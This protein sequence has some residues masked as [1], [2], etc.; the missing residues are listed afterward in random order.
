MISPFNV[1]NKPGPVLLDLSQRKHA[2][3]ADTVVIAQKAE[4]NH[5]KTSLMVKVIIAKNRK[6]FKKHVYP[7]N[8][9]EN[10]YQIKAKDMGC[11]FRTN[12]PCLLN[13]KKSGT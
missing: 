5:C 10:L 11:Y 13:K 3:L 8:M 12:N 2:M 7:L 4:R 6:S 9:F 1:H